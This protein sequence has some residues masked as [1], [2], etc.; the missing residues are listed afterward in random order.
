LP[1]VK[2]APPDCTNTTGLGRQTVAAAAAAAA[3]SAAIIPEKQVVS[4]HVDNFFRDKAIGPWE[5]FSQLQRS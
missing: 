4:L 2:V 5:L 3:A 1:G